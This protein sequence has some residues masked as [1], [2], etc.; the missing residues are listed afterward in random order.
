MRVFKSSLLL[1]A[2]LAS[3]LVS[4]AHTS[5]AAADNEGVIVA[6]A[7]TGNGAGF[8]LYSIDP[9]HLNR[10]P[11]Q[12]THLVFNPNFFFYEPQFSPD[13]RR[14][15]FLYQS[16]SEPG[17]NAYVMNADGSHLR[18]VTTDNSTVSASFSADGTLLLVG[19]ANTKTLLPAIVSIPADGSGGE[20]VLTDDLFSNSEAFNTPNGRKIIYGTQDGGVVSVAAIM[21]ADGSDKRRLTAVN[22][23]LC[24]ANVSPGG[25]KVL[26]NSFCN[27]DNKNQNIWVMNVDGTDVHQLTNPGPNVTDLAGAYSPDGTK[28]VF[29]STRAGN[30]NG[31]DCWVMNANGTGARLIVHTCGLPTWG[32][33][34]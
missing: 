25:R 7:D 23:Q 31:F 17:P 27:V 14:I 24:P 18:K 2:F 1:A 30:P 4:M 5:L 34:P 3:A 8:Q 13:G 10:P 15:A 22:D 20:R 32:I 6:V 21:N 26:L 9:Q 16:P 28:I 11:L 33:K 12:L 29:S 19:D